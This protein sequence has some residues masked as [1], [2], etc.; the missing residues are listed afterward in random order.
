MLTVAQPLREK[1][2]RGITVG[3]FGVKA[4]PS[5]LPASLFAIPMA[6]PQLLFWAQMAARNQLAAAW[7]QLHPQGPHSQ[8]QCAQQL[9]REQSCMWYRG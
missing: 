8:L 6:C 4:A 1:R 3:P 2:S 9:C 5:L 7:V